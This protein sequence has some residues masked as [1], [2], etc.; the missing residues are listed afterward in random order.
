ML[1]LLNACTAVEVKN[2]SGSARQVYQERASR[3]A[4][5]EQ[6]GLTG[7]LS[8]D[9]GQD[10]G[11]GR[12]SWQ[13]QPGASE[14]DFH[15]ALGRGAW[16]LSIGPD[17]ATLQRA[18]GRRVEAESVEELVLGEVGW[19]VPV[20]ALSWWVRGLR[21]PGVAERIELDE[22]GRIVRLGQ[23][24]WMIEFERYR[25]VAGTELPGRIEAV[26]GDLRLKLVAARWS[27]PIPAEDAR[28]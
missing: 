3:I 22:A 11:S 13:M 28:A 23:A 14:L 8:L 21:A 27:A 2:V 1:L 24:G 4:A 15:G 17:S 5:Q 19:R 10:G 7:K 26:R 20:E 25:S 16:R 12:L 9:D 6:W 18:D